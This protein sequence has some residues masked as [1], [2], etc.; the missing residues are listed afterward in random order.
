[1]SRRIVGIETSRNRAAPD[2]FSAPWLL[3]GAISC[4]ALKSKEG[5]RTSEKE[6]GS[7][8]G[9]LLPAQ[10]EASLGARVSNRSQEV[11]ALLI[12]ELLSRE[13]FC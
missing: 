6:R 13:Q 2:T 8:K 5:A 11:V 9:V 12:A 7:K 3:L 1:M 10:R 4:I